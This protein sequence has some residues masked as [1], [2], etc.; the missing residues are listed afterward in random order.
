MFNLMKQTN[1]DTCIKCAAKI[2]PNDAID[3]DSEAKDQV[4]GYMTPCYH[5][6]CISCISE[7]K[8]NV[9]EIAQG[10]PQVVCPI[11]EAHIKLTYFPLKMGGVEDEEDNRM[12]SKDSAKRAKDMSSYGGPHTKTRALISDLLA[13]RKESEDLPADKPIKSVIF[14]GWTAHLDLIQIALTANDVKYVRLDGKMTR[15]AR[16]A[17]MDQFREDPSVTVILVSITAGGLGLNLT[18]ASKVY[19]M[20]PQ[21]NPAAEAQAVDRV[22]RLGQKRPVTTVR[23][24]MNDSFEEKMLELQEKKKK[25]A[26]LSMD[27]DGRSRV[28]KAEAARKR[29]EDLRSLFK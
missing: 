23:Y 6:V 16:T 4:I 8:S 11:C 2:G 21:Y 5:A 22:H 3:V 29:L 9:E 14:S 20:E 17:A 18:T 15:P 10:R 26:H 27:S 24:I 19:V 7:Y 1:V 12:K 28:D 25:L 13:S